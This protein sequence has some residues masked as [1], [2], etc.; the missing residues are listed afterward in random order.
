MTFHYAE[1]AAN[2]LTID[3]VDPVAKIPSYKVAAVRIEAVTEAMASTTSG[4]IA[5]RP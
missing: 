1:A 3:A 2:L 4:V 5:R